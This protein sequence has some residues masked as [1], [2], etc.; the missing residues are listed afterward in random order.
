MNI[1]ISSGHGKKVRGASGVLDEVDEARKVVEQVAAYFLRAGVS[2]Q[3]FHDDISTTQ[4]ENLNRIV[5]FH[6][7][8]SRDLDVSVHFNAYQ[9]TSKPMGTECLF[10]T[11]EVLA[12]EVSASIAAASGLI[13]RGPKKR[14]DLFFLNKTEEPALL[15]EV[16]FVDSTT[17]ADLYHKHFDPICAAISEAITGKPAEVPGPTPA[18]PED[19]DPSKLLIID[20]VSI[21]QAFGGGYVTFCSDLDICNDGS[22]PDHDDVSYQPMTAYYNKGKY[23]NADE[24][25]YIV[26]PPQVRELL[27]PRKL[28]VMG[29]QARLTNMK[30]GAWTA[31]VTGEIGPEDKTGEAA[32]CAAKILNPMIDYNSGDKRRLYLYE[33]WPGLPA[34]VAGKV[35]P[36][37]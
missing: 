25:R 30:T 28:K 36:L 5:N 34:T 2:V 13:N 16:C 32:Y 1:V 21:W 4:N 29:C 31:A 9:D 26:I 18:Q 10:V 35:Y 19:F 33:L 20:P 27:E 8:Q 15:I 3:S 37:E 11:Q 22:G 12:A 17:D 7:A 6:N 14:T 24:D 23:L